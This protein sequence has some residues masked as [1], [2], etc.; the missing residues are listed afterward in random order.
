MW[1]LLQRDLLLAWRRR[2]ELL[3]PLLFLS[4][5]VVLFPLGLGTDPKQLASIAPAVLWIAALLAGLLS[6]EHVFKPDFVD[7]SLEQLL[8]SGRSLPLLAAVK[9]LAHWLVAG[10]PMLVVAPLLGV[11]LH[12]PTSALPSLMLTLLMGTPVL[13]LLGSIGVALTVG[14]RRGGMFLSLLILPLF[15]PV[16]IFATGATSAAARGLPV[17]DNLLLL[18]AITVLAATLAPFAIA[19]ALRISVSSN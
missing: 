2:G 4:M 7:G 16:L 19:A 14:L 8:L 10:L 15:V 3:T 13:S 11:T 12:L 18:A 17:T 6:L 9:V 5:V 1:A